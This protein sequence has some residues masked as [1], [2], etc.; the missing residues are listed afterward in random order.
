MARPNDQAAIKGYIR[1]LSEAKAAFQ[2]LPEAMRVRSLAA[3]EITLSE[4]VRHAKLR[5]AA[6][7]SIQ[8][9]TLYN[10][11][12][13]SL[14]KNS[15]RGKAGVTNVTSTVLFAHMGGITRKIR[16]KGIIVAGKNGS[17]STSQ[18]A[19]VIRPGR[20][21]H[22]VEFGSKHMKAEPFM[23]PAAKTQEGPYLDRMKVAGREV[24]KDLAA[25]GLRNL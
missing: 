16:V 11:I 2:A 15:N 1:G 13:Y 9:R 14:N 6:N 4:I 25:I 10:S 7:P 18:G 3:T 23:I 21:A 8:T 5:L 12:A 19:K 17:A 24:E 22:L 20:Y